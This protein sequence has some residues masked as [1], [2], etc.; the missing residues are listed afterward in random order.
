MNPRIKAILLAIAFPALVAAAK[1]A[2]Q[3]FTPGSIGYVIAASV[4]AIALAYTPSLGGSSSGAPKVPPLV[5]LLAIA[6]FAAAG[7]SFLKSEATALAPEAEAAAAKAGSCVLAQVVSGNTSAPSIA[8][9]CG[10]PAAANALA[11]AAQFA[12]DLEGAVADGG[13]G[14]APAGLPDRATLAAKLRA[15]H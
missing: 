3:T 2:E 15:V 9:K 4:L 14:A 13:L 5:V 6:L 1:S 8:V 7:C 10:L 11:I 12:T